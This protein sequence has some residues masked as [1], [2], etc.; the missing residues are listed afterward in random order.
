MVSIRFYLHSKESNKGIR[1]LY[2]DVHVDGV[3]RIRQAIGETSKLKEWNQSNQKFSARHPYQKEINARLDRLEQKVQNVFREMLDGGLVPTGAD[4][5]RL[6]RPAR[7]GKKEQA[8][9][10][11]VRQV[12]EAWAEKYV[13][14]KSVGGEKRG[15]NYSRQVKQVISHMDTFREG[16]NRRT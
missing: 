15:V 10:V 16:L 7:E 1:S 2:M 4:L 5:R 14:R 6:I 8:I 9:P 13:A 3:A 11:K 12:L